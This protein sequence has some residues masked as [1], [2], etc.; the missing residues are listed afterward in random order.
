MLRSRPARGELAL[1]RL[2]PDR[3]PVVLLGG[4]NVARAIALAGISV[5]VASTDAESPVFAS[6]YCDALLLP[7]LE[8]P[9]AAVEKL[10]RLGE[11]ISAV[12]GRP[13]PLF[14]GD[15]DYLNLILQNRARL[16]QYYRFIL[17][18]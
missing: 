7:P 8:P 12:I 15:D 9:G 13:V 5:I 4:L 2:H 6:R 10:T 17:N 16:S 11:R 18:D 1:R 14:Y 3:P